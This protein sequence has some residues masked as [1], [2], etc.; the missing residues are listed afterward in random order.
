MLRKFW[1]AFLTGMASTLGAIIVTRASKEL[2]QASTKGW[3]KDKF[4][5]LKSHLRKKK[6]GP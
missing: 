4:D 2:D 3:L 1:I 5:K 6:N